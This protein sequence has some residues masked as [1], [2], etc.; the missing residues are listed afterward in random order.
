MGPAKKTI[1][2]KLLIRGRIV[3]LL[4]IL[5]IISSQIVVDMLKDTSK[6]FHIEY[7]ELN[8]IQELKLSLYQL[9]FQSNKHT[10]TENHDDQDFFE[11]L[12]F[13]THERLSECIE[14]MTVSHNT[15]ILYDVYPKLNNIDSLSKVLFY[16]TKEEKLLLEE[17]IVQNINNEIN[18][19]LNLV[20]VILI[21]TK[22][23]VDEYA[24]TSDTIFRHSTFTILLLG[25]SI[26]LVIVIGGLKFINNLTKPIHDL[27]TT[28]KR[29]ISGD[30]GVKVEIDTGDEFS[31]LANSFNLMLDSLESST[32]TK[33]YFDNIIKNMFDSLI[34]TD[35]MLRIRSVNQSTSNLLGYSK[36]WLK[37]KNVGVIFGKDINTEN[38]LLN[39]DEI[40]VWQKSITDMSYFVQ[41]SGKHVP[42]LIS[43]SVL[44][45]KNGESEGLIIVGHDLT[46][47]IEIENELEKSRK[48]SLIDINEAQEEERMRIA[49]D[50]HDG[51]GH[52]LTSI[53]Y[54]AQELQNINVSN[55]EEKEKLINKI[56]EEIDLAIIESKNLSHNLIPIVLKDFGLIV[57][58]TNLVDRANEFYDIKIDF[59]AFDY[60]ERIDTKLEKAIYRIC[61]ESL[62]NII[63]HSKAENAQ[64]QIFKQEDILVLVIDDDGIGFDLELPE[65]KSNKGIGLV[66]IRE[67]VSAFDGTFNIESQ[68]GNGT[69]II[70]EIPIKK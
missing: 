31:I 7:H 69:E 70:I 4:I 66:S 64:F 30:R 41:S 13:Q 61:Q 39:T 36:S 49:T 34:V 50:L 20:D 29:I 16:L 40:K 8:A 60:T 12:V 24:E 3:L 42:S 15:D 21:E 51:L 48:Q 22:W 38:S 1:R 6:E 62:N 53:S 35:N 17:E 33:T 56:Q 32:V 47:R 63:K 11:I 37:G 14:E 25:I 23:E 54:S 43:C 9:L 58:I 10:L 57:A 26:A 27:V 52:L 5:I 28:T 68:P 67:R 55:V 65:E 18:E 2:N 59:N 44:K 45:T 46:K 19:S